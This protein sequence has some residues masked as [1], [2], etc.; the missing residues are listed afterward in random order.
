MRE[1]TILSFPANA[2][3]IQNT[4][5]LVKF[6]RASLGQFVVSAN[7]DFLGREILRVESTE[8]LVI[9]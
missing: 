7:E 5:Y 3:G 2:I 1:P 6:Q 4:W 9:C 8:V